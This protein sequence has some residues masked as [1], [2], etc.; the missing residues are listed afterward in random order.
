MKTRTDRVIVY[1][2]AKILVP[3]RFYAMYSDGVGVV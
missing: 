2:L 1:R 3:R